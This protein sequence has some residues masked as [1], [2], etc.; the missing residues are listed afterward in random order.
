MNARTGR[1]IPC[2]LTG[3]ESAEP[4]TASADARMSHLVN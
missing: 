3:L 4:Y 1:R 2:I